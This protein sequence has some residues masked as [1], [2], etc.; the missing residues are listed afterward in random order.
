MLKKIP[1]RYGTVR[2]RTVP[3]ERK[4]IRSD[5]RKGCQLGQNAENKVTVQIVR[6]G[7]LISKSFAL[8]KL[9]SS[10][11]KIFQKKKSKVTNTVHRLNYKSTNFIM[12]VLYCTGTESFLLIDDFFDLVKRYRVLSLVT[13]PYGTSVIK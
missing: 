1:Y 10:K 6:Y 12:L 4:L 11:S 13:V 2:Y 5:Q 7:T 8:S 9:H 3:V